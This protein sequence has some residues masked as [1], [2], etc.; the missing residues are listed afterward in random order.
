[1]NGKR[2]HRATATVSSP[3][4]GAKGEATPTPGKRLIELVTSYWQLATAL[5]GVVAAVISGLSYFATHREVLEAKCALRLAIRT[6][7]E[8]NYI[9]HLK[10]KIALDDKELDDK[11]KRP[12][13]KAEL[14][15]QLAQEKSDL[16]RTDADYKSAL[17]E[18]Q[19]DVCGS[20]S[21]EKAN[22]HEHSNK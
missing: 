4:P 8:P 10:L 20:E 15:D 6:S 9:A 7:T 17:Q 12:S 18:Y 16:E 3:P 22:A 1:M 19:S 21:E 2:G 14:Q 11:D 5:I 13:K